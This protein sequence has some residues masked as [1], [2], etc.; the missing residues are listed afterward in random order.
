MPA[1]TPAERQLIAAIGAHGR[2][3]QTSADQRHEATAAARRA[4][5]ARFEAQ[6]DPDGQLDPAERQ[7]RAQHARR[8]HMSR[9]ALKSAQARRQRA[10]DARDAAA[11]QALA[12]LGT[13]NEA[14]A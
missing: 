2:W 4:A 6:V 8:A 12:D 3:A 7:A 13:S 11:E 5:L 10:L 1:P 9:I 14:A